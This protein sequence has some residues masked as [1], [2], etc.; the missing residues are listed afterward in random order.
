MSKTGYWFDRD[1]LWAKEGEKSLDLDPLLLLF[2]E[3]GGTL[4]FLDLFIEFIDNNR[5][6]QVHNEEGCN[7][8]EHN[9]D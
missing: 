6:E 5:N 9:E 8:N 7:E 4:P 2:S 1:D 3:V